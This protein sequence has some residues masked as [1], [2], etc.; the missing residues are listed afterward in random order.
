M[1]VN[2]RCFKVPLVPWT[3]TTGVLK[4][5]WSHELEP[6]VPEEVGCLLRTGNVGV[7]FGET[8]D[9]QSNLG[10]GRVENDFDF[11]S[12]KSRNYSDLNDT[13]WFIKTSG[14]LFVSMC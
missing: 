12:L 7:A 8:E 1:N 14:M 9:Y 6:H 5:P 10:R 4:F 2:P 11:S 3:W 13:V